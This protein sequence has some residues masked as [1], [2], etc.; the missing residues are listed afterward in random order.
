VIELYC[1]GQLILDLGAAPLIL[2]HPG[3]DLVDY[4]LEQPAGVVSMDWVIIEVGPT[5]DGPWT[6]VFNWGDDIPDTNS[7]VATYSADGELDNEL[8]PTSALFGSTY[9]T[10]IALDVDGLLPPGVYSWVRILSPFGGGNDG[11][12]IDA[13]QVLP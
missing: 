5:A 7:N 10:G 11:S 4:E 2:P 1:G 3:Y 13:I 12:H 8:F 6:T 9:M